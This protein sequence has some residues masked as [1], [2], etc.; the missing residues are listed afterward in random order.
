MNENEK[1]KKSNNRK[2][3]SKVVLL[4]GGAL[5]CYTIWKDVTS[6]LSFM[7]NILMFGVS[8]V[9]IGLGLLLGEEHQ[10]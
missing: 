1:Q 6:G 8:L 9:L 2:M 3:V 7:Y 5:A 4:M 10:N